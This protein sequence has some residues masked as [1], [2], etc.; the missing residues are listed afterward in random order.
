M[1]R[2]GQTWELEI[3]PGQADL[4]AQVEADRG[5]IERF[6]DAARDFERAFEQFSSLAVP[7][8]HPMRSQYESIYEHAS[9]VRSTMQAIG[10][11]LGSVWTGA[12]R[13]FGVSGARSL[14][15]AGLGAA[16]VISWA[17][18][19]GAIALLVAATNSMMQF[20]VNWRR[21]EA[22]E[23]PIPGT[24]GGGLS[25]TLAGGASLVKWLVI[26]GIAVLVLPRVLDLLPKERR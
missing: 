25:E 12:K 1:N 15:L 26:G 16:P 4:P 21:A 19:T 10:S 24:T 13:V 7:Y 17:A 2:L 11:A 14:A 9:R 20:I 8:D 3:E 22:G 23:A 6:L 5:T 18:I